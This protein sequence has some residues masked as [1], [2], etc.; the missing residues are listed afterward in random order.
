MRDVMTILIARHIDE[1]L[2][3]Q[4][5]GHS[6]IYRPDLANNAA[7]EG[8]LLQHKPRV[9]VI[10]GCPPDEPAITGWRKAMGDQPHVMIHTAISTSDRPPAVFRRAGIETQAIF[11]SQ[12]AVHSDDLEVLARAEAYLTYHEALPRLKAAGLTDNPSASRSRSVIAVGAGIVNL[13]TAWELARAGYQLTIV[14]ACP[15]PRTKPDWRR[16]GTTHG[17][18]NARMFSLTGA[19]NY[20]EEGSLIYSG[21]NLVFRKKISEGGWLTRAAQ[22]LTST[23]SS[24]HNH[25][26]SVPVWMAEVF[27]RD[28]YAVNHE[29]M[30]FWQDMIKE[31]SGL[32]EK[33]GYV[34]DILRIYSEPEVYQAAVVL[35]RQL[36]ALKRLLPEGEVG[37]RHPAFADACL[38][39]E[40]VGGLDAVG[41]TLNIHNFVANLLNQ[42]EL[43][44]VRFLWNLEVNGISMGADGLVRELL[45]SKGA[46]RADHYVASPGIN[47]QK[48][49]S[50]TLT[51]DKIQG[52]GGL[53]LTLPN[54][55]PPLMHSVKL[56]REGHVGEDSNI[57]VASGENGEPIL[58]LGSGYAF[59]GNGKL[60]MDSLEAETL[61]KALEETAR[62]FLPRNYAKAVSDGTLRASR[63]ACIRPFTA[64]G[65]GIF[66]ILGTENG[67]RMVITTGHNTGGFTQA[68]SVAKA[69]LAT[70]DGALHPMQY[71]Y[72]PLRGF[73]NP[74]PKETHQDYRARDTAA[75][76]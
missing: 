54:V 20:N 65:L 37:K 29:S 76:L 64:T 62:R 30:I 32:F 38:S 12:P 8:A 70:L 18:G 67:G 75:K 52:I 14:D 7:L 58:L 19:D 40:I 16:L 31:F 66:E 73:I 36:G 43:L 35:Q 61:F 56:H 15:D 6:V 9:L 63:R 53:W 34:E 3:S 60:D 44:G 39:C 45:T 74:V 33:V 25:Y 51:E 22:D 49:L 26:H 1:H 11:S 42:L 41:F 57:T 28:I 4:G 2:M 68:P 21:M 69:T 55:D 17:G 48:W 24:W 23:E 72:Y 46:L 13:V 50:G 59:V 5:L 27:A 71:K 47:C 10:D